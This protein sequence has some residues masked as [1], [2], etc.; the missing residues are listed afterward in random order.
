MPP[1][2]P[3]RSTELYTVRLCRHSG[4]HRPWMRHATQVSLMLCCCPLCLPAAN[5]IP[6]QVPISLRHRAHIILGLCLRHI[7]RRDHVDD[8]VMVKSNLQQLSQESNK[9]LRLHSIWHCEVAVLWL[10]CFFFPTCELYSACGTH[11]FLDMPVAGVRGTES[12]E[13]YRQ[14]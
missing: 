3:Q 10:H 5:C 8:N 12:K 14:P 13:D 2:R 4:V 11:S 1:R 9:R 6:V 7:Y